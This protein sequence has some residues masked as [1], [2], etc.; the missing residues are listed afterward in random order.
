MVDKLTILNEIK[1]TAG[2]NNG[3][4]LGV[5]RFA[6]ETGIRIADWFGKHW[7]HWAEALTEAGFSP[8]VLQQPHEEE[9]LL[10]AMAGL[11]LEIGG[12]PVK[13]DLLFKRKRDP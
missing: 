7:K 11:V 9:V 5:A 8:N 3:K 13:G 6:D 2:E 10:K 12:I 4:P 1:R